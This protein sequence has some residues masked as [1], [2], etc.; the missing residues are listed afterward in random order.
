MNIEYK[1]H[2]GILMHIT[3]LPSRYGIGDLGKGAYDF[4]DTIWET[5]CDLWQ[6]LPLGPTGYGN[7]PYSPRSSFAA[8]EL[9]ISP[10]E[11]LNDGYLSGE[12][13]VNVPSFPEGKVDFNSVINYKIPLLKKA[14]R[15]FLKE[16]REETYFNEFLEREKYWIYDYALFM[17][18]YEKHDDARWQ[19]WPDGEKNRKDEAIEKLYIEMQEDSR[20]YLALQY[21]FTKQWLRIKSYASSKG[22]SIIGDIPIFVG[23]DSADTWSHPELFKRDEN[24]NFNKVSGV[25][26]DSFSPTGQLW[27]NPVYDWQK[28]EEDGF[29][30]WKE[31]IKRTMEFI[32]ILRI[33]HFRGFDA[34][35]EIDASAQTAEHG[36]WMKSPGDELFK[37]MK[38]EFGALNII[39]EDLGFITKSVEDLRQRYG[40]PGMKIAEDG[41]NSNPDGSLN[42]RDTFLPHN[43]E[44]SFVAYPGTHDNDTIKGWFSTLSADM[45]SNVLEY[46]DCNEKDI[47]WAMIRALMM[48]NADYTVFCTQD[49][50]GLSSEARMNTPSTCNDINWSW[51][52]TEGSFSDEIIARLRKLNKL[53]ARGR[54]L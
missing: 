16:N 26:P 3:S 31:R 21:L 10:D 47:N 7:S 48:S 19:L 44:R 30:W 18:L 28:H 22:I 8:N 15:N 43:Y 17:V 20:V 51:R 13:I 9:L 33:D 11:L 38:N 24:G 25:P 37:A 14:G 42:T 52:M 1:R 50:L 35:F 5:G 49:L 27:G 45:Q 40:F 2:N 29:S 4:I 32:D 12:D 54:D 53:S 36:I 23:R 34:Y 46:L 41:F 39:A 6:I